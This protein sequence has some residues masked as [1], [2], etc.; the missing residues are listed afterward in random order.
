MT[1]EEARAF[2]EELSSKMRTFLARRLA[3]R[4]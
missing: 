3:I 1:F 2:C 4:K